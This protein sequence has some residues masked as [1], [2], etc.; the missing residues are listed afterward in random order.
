VP[1]SC[2]VGPREI[3]DAIQI[4]TS[5]PNTRYLGYADGRAGHRQDV[6]KLA[7]VSRGAL[8]QALIRAGLGDRDSTL[9]ALERLTEL[10]RAASI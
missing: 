8:R 9:K 1:G 10:G 2:I 7:F 3:D 6:E 5:A 4:L